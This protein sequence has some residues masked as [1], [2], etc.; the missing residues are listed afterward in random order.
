MVAIQSAVLYKEGRCFS[1]SQPFFSSSHNN[2]H[3]HN[4]SKPFPYFL[5]S[6]GV[7]SHFPATLASLHIDIQA[8]HHISIF[9]LKPTNQNALD[10]FCSDSHFCGW[11]FCSSSYKHYYHHQQLLRVRH[12]CRWLL[13]QPNHNQLCCSYHFGF[14]LLWF[15]HCTGRQ[16]QPACIHH[17][18]CFQLLRIRHSSRR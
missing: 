17:H 9:Q 5:V 8:F 15:W 6:F 7:S 11:C 3:K 16:L 4:R 18:I 10:C 2:T 12:Q 14:R 1:Y 13:R